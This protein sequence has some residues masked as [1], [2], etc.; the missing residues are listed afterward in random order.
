M[1]QVQLR[2]KLI[3]QDQPLGTVWP[4]S[5]LI[6]DDQDWSEGKLG[7]NQWALWT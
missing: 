2:E 6:H 3:A 4:G 5:G 1:A 7:G